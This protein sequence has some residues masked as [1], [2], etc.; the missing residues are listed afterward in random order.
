MSNGTGMATLRIAQEHAEQYSKIMQQHYEAMDCFDC[1][2]YLQSGIDTF[3][4]FIRAD[5]VIRLAIYKEVYGHDPKID[6]VLESLFRGW[7]VN[8]PKAEE[9]VTVQEK[10]GYTVS[11]LDEFRH[12]CE[13]TRAIV[14]SLDSDKPHV[15]DKPLISLRDEALQDYSNGQTAEFF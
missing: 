7:L 12:C 11:N 2:A 4:W 1:E 8:C 10:R 3:R 6:Q 13:E 9:W 14:E 5:R 15:M